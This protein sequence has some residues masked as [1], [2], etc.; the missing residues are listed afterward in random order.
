MP[1]YLARDRDGGLRLHPGLPRR[2]T[3]LGL[4][5]TGG[6]ATPLPASSFP[7]LTWESRPLPVSLAPHARTIPALAPSG[8]PHAAPDA[9]P[10]SL[11]KLPA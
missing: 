3:D 2:N 9:A 6:E 7:G 4:W 1:L 11:L 5:E 8:A 10:D